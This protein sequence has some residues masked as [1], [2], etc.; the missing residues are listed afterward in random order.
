MTRINPT[1]HR[2]RTRWSILLLIS[3]VLVAC[4]GT[5]SN[6][7]QTKMYTIG[8][9][10]YFPLL[11]RAME[12]FKTGMTELGYVEGK[13]VRYIYNGVIGSEPAV[14]EA[15]IKRLMGEK[16]DLLVTQG[17]PVAQM[18]RKLVAGTDL[19]VI[20]V[21]IVNPVEAGIVDSISHP[22]G[23]ITGVQTVNKSDKV[24]EWLVQ[25]IPT[26]KKV[27]VFYHSADAVS[28]TIVSRMPAAAEQSGVELM[29]NEVQSPEQAME[30]I[31]TMP[32]DAA[33]LI[34]P[35]PSLASGVSAM[36]KLALERGIPGGAYD[37]PAED[38]VFSF[39]ADFIEEGKQAARMADKLLKGQKPAELPVETAEYFLTINLPVAK[40]VNIEIAD[41][42]LSQANR[43][44]R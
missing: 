9:V 38:L 21:P 1:A 35:A 22:G 20:F 44:I 24:M 3:L 27:Y 17:T 31:K 6:T 33:L 42:F 16:I 40:T 11:E 28:K 13:N 30:I 41:K 19:P 37:Q 8:I 34:I 4:G 2:S 7:T 32:K 10:N 29:L 25:L 12:G 36:K 18:A 5:S 14:I 26:A 39:S 15:E 23:N 43:V